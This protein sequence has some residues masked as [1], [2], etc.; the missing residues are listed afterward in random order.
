MLRFAPL[1]V[2]GLQIVTVEGRKAPLSL[3]EVGNQRCSSSQSLLPP[4][5]AVKFL[6]VAPSAELCTQVCPHGQLLHTYSPKMVSPT[7]FGLPIITQ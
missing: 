5:P 2:G 4:C 7:K 3:K 6:S 1:F